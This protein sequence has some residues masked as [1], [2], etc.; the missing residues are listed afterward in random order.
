MHDRF[1]ILPVQTLILFR[2]TT[3]KLAAVRL[4]LK[5]I[6]FGPAGGSIDFLSTTTVHPMTLIRLV[7]E[8][9]KELKLDSAG[10]RLRVQHPCPDVET[11]FT[12]IQSL[13]AELAANEPIQPRA[14]ARR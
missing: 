7:Q 8:R 5:R 3:I 10:Q 2:V 6:D 13:L 1:G 11:R 14:A 9:P 12:V 4:G